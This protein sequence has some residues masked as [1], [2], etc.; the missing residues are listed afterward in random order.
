[1]INSSY[2]T[3]R[4]DF[5]SVDLRAKPNVY[6]PILWWEYF[7][8]H[9]SEA[10]ELLNQAAAKYSGYLDPDGLVAIEEVRSDEL[11][12]FRFPYLGQ[13]ESDNKQR[14]PLPLTYAFGIPERWASFDVMLGKLRALVDHA[15][16]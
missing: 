6:P 16:S 12:S 2:P 11:V 15:G 3:I 13:L 9:A 4:A 5:E 7:A 10:R 8:K 14:D 1:L